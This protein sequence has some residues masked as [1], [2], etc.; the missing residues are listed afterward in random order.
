MPGTPISMQL[1]HWALRLEWEG[2]GSRC[3][4]VDLCSRCHEEGIPIK[5]LIQMVRVLTLDNQVIDGKVAA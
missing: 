4:L 3:E 2:L 5:S 1:I